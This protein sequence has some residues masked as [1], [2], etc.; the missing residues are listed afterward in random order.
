M[1]VMKRFRNS[2]ARARADG[3]RDGGVDQPLAQIDQVLEKR[4]TP[5]EFI[6][7]RGG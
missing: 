2:E 3:N 1:N 7:G 5:A 4:H 6:L